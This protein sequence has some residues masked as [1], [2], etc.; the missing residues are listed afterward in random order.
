MWCTL[1]TPSISSICSFIF[2][3]STLCGVF[4]RNKSITSFK[5]LIAFISI[6]IDTPIDKIGSIRV[7]SVNLIT[8]APTSTVKPTTAAPTTATPTIRDIVSLKVEGE[9]IVD[10]T[11]FASHKLKVIAVNKNGEEAELSE[12]KY[13]IALPTETKAKLMEKTLS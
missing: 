3:I 9:R 11:E 2:E 4:S 13:D 8:I 6:K 10:G 1:I 7:K 12:D 5:F